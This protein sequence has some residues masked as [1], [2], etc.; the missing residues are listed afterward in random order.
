M[1]HKDCHGQDSR[2]QQQ[3]FGR[4]L[5][6]VP[7][8]IYELLNWKHT[9]FKLMDL[10]ASYGSDGGSSDTDDSLDCSGPA[11]VKKLKADESSVD[12]IEE[13]IYGASSVSGGSLLAASS[14]LFGAPRH[15]DELGRVRA[16]PHVNGNW[17]SIIYVSCT[18]TPCALVRFPVLRVTE[19][20][21][22][23]PAP[24][25]CDM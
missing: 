16:F 2:S 18:S 6:Q 19:I 1:L 8:D 3:P 21:L 9:K 4:I 22:L 20:L 10:L 13:N 23:A 5:Q 14:R 15:L 12:K 25:A 24:L 17:P 7:R 11:A